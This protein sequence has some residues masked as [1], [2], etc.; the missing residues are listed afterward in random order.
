MTRS[1]RQIPTEA[2]RQPR[3]QISLFHI[4]RDSA[5]SGKFR[6]PGQVPAGGDRDVTAISRQAREGTTELALRHHLTLDI[7]NLMNTVRLDAVVSLDDAPFVQR[8]VV[9]FGFQ[10]MS[11]LS[12]SHQTSS[13]IA[14]SIR[15]SLIRHEPRLIASTIEVRV[16]DGGEGSDQ[17]LSF[18]VS[19]EMMASP[20]DIP[21]DFVAEVD[22]GA[23]KILMSRLRVQK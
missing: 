22:L 4:F 23:G 8:S 5:E 3:R 12:R 21:L 17:R 13:R 14:A 16:R 10:D 1:P 9:N 7:A 19:A 11:S 18:D 2:D 15:E 6:R 20:A